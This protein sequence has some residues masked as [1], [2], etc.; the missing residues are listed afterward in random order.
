MIDYIPYFSTLANRGKHNLSN[1]KDEA[2]G[3][4]KNFAQCSHEALLQKSVATSVLNSKK[5]SDAL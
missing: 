5:L 4:N 2:D 1:K 3:E